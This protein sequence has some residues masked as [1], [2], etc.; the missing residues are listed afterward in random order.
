MKKFYRASVKFFQIS[1][2]FME[3]SIFVSNPKDLIF[4]CVHIQHTLVK[5]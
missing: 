4:Q 2:I 1:R 3:E 5:V